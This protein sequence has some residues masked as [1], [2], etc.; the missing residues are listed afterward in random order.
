M[1]SAQLWGLR[2]YIAPPCTLRI[3]Q[4]TFFCSYCFF[5]FPNQR[6]INRYPSPAVH[7]N[8]GN[9]LSAPDASRLHVVFAKNMQEHDLYNAFHQ[10]APGL[11]Y[12]S[13][14]KDKPCAFVKYSTPTSALLAMVRFVCSFFYYKLF[15]SSL[16]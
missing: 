14:H 7:F 5:V 12:V 9:F 2:T 16:H 8:N 15:V 4:C 13:R 6:I 1:H 3:T 11:Q 10:V